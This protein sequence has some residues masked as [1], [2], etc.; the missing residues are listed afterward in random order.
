MEVPQD[1]EGYKMCVYTLCEL[2]GADERLELCRVREARAA[3]P[4]GRDVRVFLAL[5]SNR[6]MQKKEEQI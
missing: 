6:K 4:V 2:P 5:F 3:P 1:S